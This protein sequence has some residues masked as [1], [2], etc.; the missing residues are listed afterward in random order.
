VE[1]AVRIDSRINRVI[2]IMLLQE[3]QMLYQQQYNIYYYYYQYY[4]Y[5]YYYYYCHTHGSYDSVLNIMQ[6]YVCNYY[7]SCHEG[8]RGVN[9]GTRLYRWMGEFY[10]IQNLASLL[11][12][13]SLLAIHV[14]I[15]PYEQH[16][17]RVMLCLRVVFYFLATYSIVKWLHERVFGHDGFH[18]INKSCISTQHHVEP[19]TTNQDREKRTSQRLVDSHVNMNYRGEELLNKSSITASDLSRTILSN[20]EL[21]ELLTRPNTNI[22]MTGFILKEMRPILESDLLFRV[23]EKG[24]CRLL[25][26]FDGVLCQRIQLLSQYDPS[27]LQNVNRDGLTVAQIFE[28]NRS[29]IR[30]EQMEHQKL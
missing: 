11:Y 6:D 2:F 5:C 30:N 4:Y 12:S 14:S 10:W 22:A 7:Y 21:N 20:G 9:N 8:L 16:Y 23:I 19:T 26:C 24:S 13:L 28:Y 27:I 15:R 25:S 1:Q 18:Q 3:L 29:L 17:N